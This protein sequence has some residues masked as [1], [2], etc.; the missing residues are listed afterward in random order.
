[1]S[2]SRELVYRKGEV[3]FRE[4]DFGSDIYKINHAK[5]KAVQCDPIT[6]EVIRKGLEFIKP[7]V[8]FRQQLTVL[9]APGLQQQHQAF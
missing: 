3:I 9:R 7:A 2:E 6:V 4:G 5:G 1:M 8:K